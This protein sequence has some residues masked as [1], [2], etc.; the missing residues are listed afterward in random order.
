MAEATQAQSSHRFL[1][2]KAI[3]AW[4]VVHKWTS[5]ICTAFM[6][7]LCI[8]G[9]PLIFHDEIDHLSGDAVEAP[10][11]PAGT[12]AVSMDKVTAASLVGKPGAVIRYLFW[13]NDENPNVTFVGIA[14]SADAPPDSVRYTPVDTRTGVV[15]RKAEEPGGFMYV[16][17]K[18]HVDLFAG[19]PGTLFLGFMGLLLVVATLSGVVLYAPFMRRLPFGTVRRNR[20]AGTRW[21]DM[22]NMLGMVTLVWV[23]VVGA[24]GVINTC[25]QLMFGAWRNGQL[26][27]MVAPYRNVPPLEEPGSIERALATARAAAPDKNPRFVAYPGTLF[28]SKHH[29]AVFMNGNTPLTARLVTPALVDARTGALTDMRALPWYLTALLVSQPLH[30]GDYGGLPMKIIW[31]ALDLLTIV[32]L[33]SGLY[34]WIVRR[35]GAGQ[36]AADASEVAGQEQP[37]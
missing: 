30:F 13:D 23:L 29:F 32:I 6:L 24:T 27:E 15:L 36:V 34:L 17:L 28:S 12:P 25:A 37:A 10:V 31:A 33:G 35:K 20:T 4:Y 22:H 9:L 18:L 8:T 16:M 1:S 7:H 3:R 2:A 14:P 19:L 26:A 5:L 21:L 11:L